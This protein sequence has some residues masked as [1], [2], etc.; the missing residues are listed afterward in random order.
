MKVQLGFRTSSL[1]LCFL[2]ISYFSAFFYFVYITAFILFISIYFCFL[3]FSTLMI[4]HLRF[5]LSHSV[6]PYFSIT[7][8]PSL[9][10]HLS[11]S[12][13]LSTSLFFN[14]SHSLYL[15]LYLSLSFSILDV[16]DGMDN[17]ASGRSRPNQVSRYFDPR[18]L[19]Y[20]L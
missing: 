12:C 5:Y 1:F 3:S 6:S 13:S 2:V 8:T 11:S 15:S 7:L 10:R 17:S 14:H 20:N 16:G 18:S 9:S 19:S 4:L